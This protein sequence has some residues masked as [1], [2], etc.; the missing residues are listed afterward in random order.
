MML[1]A[2]ALAG[3]PIVYTETVE[4]G[5]DLNLNGGWYTCTSGAAAAAEQ[6][7]QIPNM[8]RRR[9]R[10]AQLGCRYRSLEQPSATYKITRVV[11]RICLDRE[12]GWQL[13]QRGRE[14]TVI[15]GR[16]AHVVEGRRGAQ[17]VQAI[18]LSLD[19]DYD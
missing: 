14:A 1:L 12:A 5:H 4:V 13:T 2:M 18:L 16:E 19:Q 7:I 10:S 8:A 15:C 6:L 3:A 17:V 11:S 9:V